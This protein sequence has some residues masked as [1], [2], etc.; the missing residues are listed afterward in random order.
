MLS[1]LHHPV[2]VPLSI[3]HRLYVLKGHRWQ[4]RS[5]LVQVLTRSEAGTESLEQIC[6][7]PGVHSESCQIMPEIQKVI[8][9]FSLLQSLNDDGA[10]DHLA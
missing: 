6:A 7:G 5:S 1:S 10:L 2:R 8:S 9:S 3:L 4:A